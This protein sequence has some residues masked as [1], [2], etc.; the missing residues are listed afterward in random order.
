M[1]GRYAKTVRELRDFLFGPASRPDPTGSRSDDVLGETLD[2]GG[3]GWV[4]RAMLA[5]VPV[6]VLGATVLHMRQQ[7]EELL[8]QRAVE[9][10]GIFADRYR[11]GPLS[12]GT[13]RAI[14]K[15]VEDVFAPVYEGIPGFLDWHYSFAGQYTELFGL[16]SSGMLQEKVESLLFGS[17]EERIDEAVDGVGGVMR[18]RLRAE[19]DQWRAR[20]VDSVSDGL[21]ADYE[22]ILEP[23]LADAERR[24]T[25][26][27]GPT[28]LS[29]AMAGVGTSLG[30]NA[31]GA[32]LAGRLSSRLGGT[33]VRAAVGSI[34]PTLA[35]SAGIVAWLGVDFIARWVGE[36]L[37][38]EELEAELI[39]VV[40]AEKERLR[41]ELT[42]SAEEAR[43]KP[44]G[45]FIP[46]GIRGGR[47]VGDDTPPPG[48]M[49]YLGGIPLPS[50]I[51]SMQ[52]RN[53]SLD[54]LPPIPSPAPPTIRNRIRGVIEDFMEGISSMGRDAID[55][56]QE[57]GGQIQ[58]L[59]DRLGS[60]L[61]R[62]L[63]G[64]TAH[65]SD[66]VPR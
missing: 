55:G 33:A 63:E 50:D 34:A 54:A 14:D 35:L 56:M 49:T 18:E 57:T 36:R 19:L 51:E 60:G 65:P 62:L 16:V 29:A 41:S 39:A 26:S 53:D 48:A 25:L 24:F 47:F 4:G 3:R 66:T 59:L 6:V 37:G 30:V 17:L 45:P 44:L 31:L 11:R 12:Q 40:D 46:S 52:A 1:P 64:E 9:Q 5:L 15:G 27:T 21:R 13:L 20:E 23:M 22:R 8:P 42:S 2:A 10:M 43:A 28:A 32:A 7:R 61:G 58:E 38:R